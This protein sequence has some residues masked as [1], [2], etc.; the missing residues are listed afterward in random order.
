[1][2]WLVF[3]LFFLVGCSNAIA[4]ETPIFA[5][6]SS[7]ALTRTPD[8]TK[9]A[10]FVLGT[11]SAEVT[12]WPTA[13]PPTPI[14]SSTLNTPT[15]EV[16]LVLSTVN[17]GSV[18]VRGAPNTQAAVVGGVLDGDVIVH[19]LYDPSNLQGF[20][21]WVRIARGD[22]AGNWLVRNLLTEIIPCLLGN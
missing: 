20:W 12:T 3:A 19:E 6:A 2:K 15:Q 18:F 9:L 10:T 11:A 16:C 7:A 4:T 8:K 1:M 14:A 17:V 5:T 13:A 22:L 21:E